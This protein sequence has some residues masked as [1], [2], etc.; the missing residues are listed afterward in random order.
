MNKNKRRVSFSLLIALPCATESHIFTQKLANNFQ[1][2]SAN[3]TTTSA[4]S[5]NP[6]AKKDGYAIPDIEPFERFYSKVRVAIYEGKLKS[7]HILE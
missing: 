5:N 1:S 4:T 2:N 7:G 6:H 3:K